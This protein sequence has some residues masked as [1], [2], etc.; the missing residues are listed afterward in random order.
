MR[1]PI[2]PRRAGEDLMSLI[3][4]TN[5]NVRHHPRQCHPNPH[6]LFYH[7]TFASIRGRLQRSLPTDCVVVG[8]SGVGINLHW[9]MNHSFTLLPPVPLIFAKQLRTHFAN[10]CGS[11]SLPRGLGLFARFVRQCFPKSSMILSKKSRKSLPPAFPEDL[12][13]CCCSHQS[14]NPATKSSQSAVRSSGNGGALS[15]KRSRA[16]R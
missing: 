3:N 4:D 11:P 9:L 8:L 13:L 1:G 10:A 12:V 5:Y 16:S 2:T 6:A 7:R 15:R 14:G